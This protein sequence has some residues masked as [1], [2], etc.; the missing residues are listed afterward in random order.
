MFTLVSKFVDFLIDPFLK[1]H[2]CSSKDLRE[3][4]HFDINNPEDAP[5]L[6]RSQNRT[7]TIEGKVT[8]LFHGNGLINNEIYFSLS[9]VNGNHLL[10]VGDKVET[11]A[12]QQNEHG[13]WHAEQINV[14]EKAWEAEVKE[15][16]E[17]DLADL[18]KA[19]V[20]GKVTKFH[21]KHGAINSEIEFSLSDCSDGFVPAKGD[22]VSAYVE[23]I[24]LE[25]S[26]GREQ[27][28]WDS[29]GPAK[30]KKAWNVCPARSN[31]IEGR[32]TFV[33]NDYG[34]INDE[35][36]FKLTS[37]L[38]GY[39]PK[40]NDF[41]KA[42]LVESA[43]KKLE[44][45]AINI[46]PLSSASDA[47]RSKQFQQPAQK[48]S[49]A[50]LV[51]GQRP[52]FS[53]RRLI[54]PVKLPHFTVPDYLESCVMAGGELTE[55]APFLVQALNAPTYSRRMS[56]L[57]HL[58]EIQM[59]MDIRQFDLTRV[60]LHPVGEYLALTV[61]GLA[62]GR[63]SVLIGDKIILYSPSDPD[64]PSYEGYVHELTCTDVFLKF[65]SSFHCGYGGEDY[66]VEFTFNRGPLRKCHQAVSLAVQYLGL[67]VLF[68][69]ELEIKAPQV[70]LSDIMP[71][72]EIIYKS[73][74]LA[75]DESMDLCHDYRCPTERYQFPKKNLCSKTV[76]SPDYTVP[77]PCR[78]GLKFFNTHLNKR[79]KAAVMNILIG[80]CRPVPY[81][82]FGPP[83]TGK[84]ITVVEAILQVLKRV[85]SSRIVACTP[86][87]SAADLIA[88][89]LHLSGQISQTDMVRLN[90]FQRSCDSLPESILKYCRFANDLEAISHFRIIVSTC[91]MAGSMYG[92]G[93]SAGHLTHV[94]VDECGQAT[95]PECLIPVG[96]V[97]GIDG[98]IIL[99]GDPKQLGPVIA[100][101]FA[102]MY[103]LEMSLLER[104]MSR[105]LYQRDEEKFGLDGGFNPT[106]VTMLVNNYR[107][108][109][110][111][112]DLPSRLFYYSQLQP[113]ADPALTHTL[114]NWSLLP[115]SGFPVVFHGI[116]GEDI[117]ENNSPSWFNPGETM[118]VM[119]YLQGALKE[120]VNPEEIGIITP[121]R[122]Q[123]EKIRL[124]MEQL[125][126]P[127]VKVG[128]VEEFQGQERQVIIISTVRSNE[129]L[130]GFDVRHTLGFLSNPKRFNVAI[131]R[132]QALMILV[133]NPHVLAQD[134]HWQVLIKHC[135]ENGGYT[136]CDLP[137]FLKYEERDAHCEAG[138]E[139]ESLDNS[140]HAK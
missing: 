79:Q 99:A 80:Q 41:V 82:I 138:E 136:G 126:M 56:L 4:S 25:I 65:N 86:S 108:H 40:K 1:P 98:Q 9:D 72:E 64:G 8:H 109:P 16:T 131:T 116:R 111:I 42:T 123:G 60:C 128:S 139:I 45:R 37:C 70:K 46:Y 132:A 32:V 7:Q 27:E 90:A 113:H 96:L 110:A 28:A 92:L 30:I 26:E 2:E 38:N 15:T 20:V 48:G 130:I 87:N 129:K 68:P 73:N 103:G 39:K 91:I 140:S 100:S 104:L 77:V 63:P 52:K 54:L 53:Q 120:G 137:D 3:E 107:S 124:M 78:K 74:L 135:S 95:E 12:V 105:D 115:T 44:W 17:I 47:Y 83:G 84:T 93:L 62:E 101:P 71:S 34:F 14:L 125:N 24:E 6:T 75:N 85:P 81:V 55:I 76:S 134:P 118:Q 102:K 59:Q 117:R 29:Q 13:G 33:K 97:S 22:W 5:F 50:F 43:Q 35:I 31:D 89:R 114:S 122:K 19:V 11:K 106:L 127:H 36:H 21:N 121:Y 94:F 10:Q 69:K 23:E 61:P 49:S 133:G 57:L 67:K 58:E 51:P 88:E 112:L 18:H 119:R 66:N